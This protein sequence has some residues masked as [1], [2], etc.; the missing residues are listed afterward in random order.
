[1]LS[2]VNLFFG[3]LL[4]LRKNEYLS[5]GYIVVALTVGL[6]MLYTASLFNEFEKYIN[7]QNE[8]IC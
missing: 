7:D 3:L 5:V 1:V 2:A 8:N 4:V 6:Y